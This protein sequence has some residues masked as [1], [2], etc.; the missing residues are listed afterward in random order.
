MPVVAYSL[1]PS[2]CPSRAVLVLVF[3]RF[4]SAAQL[5]LVLVLLQEPI[6][7]WEL[8]EDMTYLLFSHMLL[9]QLTFILRPFARNGLSLLYL[10]WRRIGPTMLIWN[11]RSW[12]SDPK[13]DSST[14]LTVG[15]GFVS[16]FMV[17]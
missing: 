3:F 17:C 11:A 6:R 9:L 7:S 10:L 14:T 2:Q 4:A 13:S 1:A 12:P 8:V 15:K 16:T 5:V